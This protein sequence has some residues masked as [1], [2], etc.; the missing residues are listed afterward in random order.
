MM[1]T[2]NGDTRVTSISSDVYP[3]HRDIPNGKEVTEQE[4]TSSLSE[5]EVLTRQSK[6]TDYRPKHRRSVSV[7]KFTSGP[8]PFSTI[9]TAITTMAPKAGVPKPGPAKLS[10]KAGLDEWLEQAKL[11]RYLPESAM[12]QL[13][14]IVKECLMEG[15]HYFTDSFITS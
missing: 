3:H 12:K 15:K 13:C 10:P 11:C 8:S 6:P 7:H 14:E 9:T 2:P 4:L 1:E 5:L